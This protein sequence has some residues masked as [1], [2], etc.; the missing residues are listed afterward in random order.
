[1]NN[2]F[3]ELIIDNNHHGT[4]IVSLLTI[5]KI[6]LY[7]IRDI[8]HQYFVDK[9]EYRMMDNF[10]LHIY[11][12]GK[13]ITKKDLNNLTAEINE[14]IIKK[15]SYSLQIKPKNISITFHH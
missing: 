9:I 12:S 3:N 8:I 10:L 7:A 11:I 2:N 14:A 1:M 6:I 5:K 13:V 15:L 4:I